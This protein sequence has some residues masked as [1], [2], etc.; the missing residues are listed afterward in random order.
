MEE[1][2]HKGCLIGC[3]SSVGILV[4][5]VMLMS[6]MIALCIRGCA[7]VAT[8]DMSEAMEN[9]AEKRPQDEVP[10]KK[11]W[12]SGKG[13]TNAA[14]VLKIRLRGIISESIQRNIFDPERQRTLLLLVL[15]RPEPEL[16][17]GVCARALHHK[18][19]LRK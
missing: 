4:G 18:K 17:A 2:T 8:S 16:A 11:T 3:L 1:N 9:A 5:I 13:G 19:K 7:N 14:H 6:A 10:Y 12:L 15:R